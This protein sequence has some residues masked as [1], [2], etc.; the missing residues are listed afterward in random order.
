MPAE[1]H[2]LVWA[3]HFS[4]LKYREW[5]DEMNKT[6]NDE[7]YTYDNFLRSIMDE[8]Q[9]DADDDKALSKRQ[10]PSWDDLALWSAELKKMEEREKERQ[11][12]REET[13][14][15]RQKTVRAV[16]AIQGAT[17]RDEADEAAWAEE[18]ERLEELEEVEEADEAEAEGALR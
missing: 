14:L 17:E 2:H 11:Q 13:A 18:M 7:G 1:A 12:Q 5:L 4:E 6:E 8:A 10:A 15:K 9:Q 3:T 16:R